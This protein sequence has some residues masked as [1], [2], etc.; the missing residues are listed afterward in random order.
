MESFGKISKDYLNQISTFKKDMLD[1][2]NSKKKKMHS[3]KKK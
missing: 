3:N 1:L 2:I